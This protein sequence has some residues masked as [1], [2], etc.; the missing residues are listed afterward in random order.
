MPRTLL[1]IAVLLLPAR[2]LAAELPAGAPVDGVAT[3][4]A[5]VRPILKAH[6]W[7][8]HGEEAKLEGSLDARL[9]RFLLRGGDSG[10]ALVPGDHTASLLVARITAGEMPPG[11]K[12]LSAAEV[13]AIVRWIDAGAQ[14]ARAEPESLAAGD[15]FSEEDRSH[16]SFQPI[17][18]PAVPQSASAELAATPIDAFLLA[19]LEARS[20]GF[21][22]PA[23]RAALIRRLSFDLIG[24][25]PEPDAVGRFVNDPSP[26]AYERL[27][28]DLLASPAYGQRWGRH[29]LD[30]AG[31]ADSDGYAAKDVERPWA[32]K[33]RDYVIRSFNQDKPW[34]EFLVEQ[35]AGDELLAP[36][37]ANLTAA[38][39]DRLIATGFLRM[40]PDGTTDSQVDQNVA[41]NDVMADTIKIVSTSLLG[42][43]VG[44]AQCHS[45]R[46]DPITH[47]DYH[48]IRALFE[49]AYDWR[50][51]R[52][53]SDRLISLWSDELKAK[54][55]AVDAELKEIADRRTEELDQLVA[56]TF[57]RELAKLPEDIQP[58][59]REAR[60]T[61]DDKQSDEQKQL[62][63]EYPFL[64]VDRGSVYLYLDDRLNGFNNKWDELTEAKR[65]QR[66]PDDNVACLTEVPGHL[67]PTL[68]FAR[69]DFNQP[70]AEIAP[71]ELAVLNRAELV[72]PSKD[73]ALPTSGRRLAYA[74]HLTDGTHPLVARVL[75]NRFWLH[76]FGRGL[77]DT[78]GDFGMLGQRPSHPQLLDWLADEFMRGGWKLKPLHRL[79]VTS[80]AYRQS[81]ER[82]EELEAVDPDNRLLGRMN[83]RR[84][85]AETIRDALLAV[86][87]SLSPRM[88]GKPVPV[89]PDE[90][91]QIVVGVDTRDSAGRPSGKVVPLGE[92]AFRRSVYVQVR[93]SMP[94]GMLEPFDVPT[95]TPNCDQRASST[96]A[97][98]SLLMMN[99]ALVVEQAGV[100]AARVRR[101]AGDDPA[102]QFHHAWLLAFGRQPTAHESEGGLAFLT[103]QAA[104]ARADAAASA[105]GTP[106][107]NTAAPPEQ[108]ALAHLCHA[109]L[110][111]NGFLYVD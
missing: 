36:P 15:V 21:G 39:A 96:V 103:E 68:L 60:E 86:S 49:P 74:R 90:V 12:K 46:Y 61:A 47:D 16:W 54:A 72:V 29:W 66:P 92:A 11:E 24:L 28:D 102:A 107:P 108:A 37:Y 84:L 6:C 67:P 62:I 25:P 43:T 27:V 77:V 10:P 109:L 88:D 23:Q 44:C 52:P 99:S 76:H 4:E 58:K 19:Q 91:G 31:Y 95:M 94:L 57:E 111:S 93:R 9:A 100:M 32:F 5:N 51:W 14:T 70:R 33:Y 106:D 45:H 63:K 40:G 50:N 30:V 35:L 79:I 13:Q 8:C 81:S 104:S 34:D 53:A 26:A 2:L 73:A 78:P 69:G 20:L 55:A 97:P 83:V 41:R 18:R 75:V 17:R 22:P 71:G 1:T 110:I 42:L 101:E 82:R 65:N 85:E 3:F 80:T 64:K 89:M 7:Q 98:Q 38:D 59:A 56:A 105:A 87:G 48:R